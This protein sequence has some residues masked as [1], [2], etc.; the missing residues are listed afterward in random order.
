M[1]RFGLRGRS[2]GFGLLLVALTTCLAGGAVAAPGDLHLVT[3]VSSFP[4]A[5]SQDQAAQEGPGVS[6]DGKRVAF[7]TTAPLVPSDP[8][9]I[10][11]DA[12]LYDLGTATYT[13]VS[14]TAAGVQANAQSFYVALSA[15]GSKVAFDSA[16]TNLDSSDTDSRFDVYVKDVSTGGVSLVSTDGTAPLGGEFPS[17]SD[18]GTRIA[19]VSGGHDEGPIWVRNT[20]A[21]TSTEVTS[22]ISAAPAISGDGTKVAFE[23]STALL[24]AD[25]NSSVDVY[26]EDLASGTLSLASTG[27]TAAP[28]GIISELP[29]LSSDGRF[30]AFDSLGAN[31]DPADAA[32][33]DFDVFRKDLVTGALTLVSNGSAGAP[34]TG[35]DASI[36]A[37][38]TKIAYDS[39]GVWVADLSSGTTTL[40]STTATG[41]PVSSAQRLL[42]EIT[43]DG[44]QVAFGTGGFY[45]VKELLP[46]A[47][48][49]TDSDG[50][51]VDDG[52]DTGSGTFSDGTTS[53]AIVDAAGNT[54]AVTDAPSP[55]G[56][57][58]TVTGT[59]GA[60]PAVFSACGFDTVRLVPGTDAVLTCGSVKLKV[61]AGRA[62]V[63]LGGGITVVSI[64]AGAIAEVSDLGAGKFTVQNQSGSTAAVTVTTNGMPSTVTAGS[65]STLPVVTIGNICGLTV[66]DIHGSAKYRSLTAKQ[67]QAVDALANAACTV[68]KTITPKLNAKQKAALIVAYKSA[69]QA[70]VKPGWLTQAD[71]TTLAGLAGT[72]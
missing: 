31:L 51:G 23:T 62:E 69:L 2:L 15:D 44:T 59:A 68:L 35:T 56:V 54:V 11:Y 67:K 47:S 1:R 8:A 18:D 72:L 55:D 50:D 3:T 25:T 43:P 20:A 63:Q 16:A 57:R 29:S 49:P 41:T 10:S 60:A 6:A 5:G 71:A 7:W 65:T 14:S 66:Q 45:W 17:I 58:I 61:T 39:S 24:P 38:G 33:P 40:A 13:L 34:S 22:A 32:T 27:P 37:D 12:Y 21:G 52:I 48:G 26:V 46:A 64:P 36:S 53:G 9:S 19:F 70:L 30:V 4:Q 42:P 28:G